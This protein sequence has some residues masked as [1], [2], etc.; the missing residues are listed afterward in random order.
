MSPC[1]NM[2]FPEMTARRSTL[3]RRKAVRGSGRN[4][5]LHPVHNYPMPL[6]AS[7]KGLNVKPVVVTKVWRRDTR[8][9][10]NGR[11]E[12]LGKKLNVVVKFSLGKEEEKCFPCV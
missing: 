11:G 12:V 3:K 9:N 8:N 4:K 5:T 6:V 7:V 10:M 2:Y 1:Q